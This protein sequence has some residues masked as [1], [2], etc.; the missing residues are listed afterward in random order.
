MQ[1]RARDADPARVQAGA[2]LCWTP[3]T[4]LHPTAGLQGDGP[5]PPPRYRS[6]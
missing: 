6:K 2:P 5:S 4:D 1:A 3:V